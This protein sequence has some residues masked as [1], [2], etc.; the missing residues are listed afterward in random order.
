M[1]SSKNGQLG[2]QQFLVTTD[3]TGTILD[4]PLLD[5]KKEKECLVMEPTMVVFTLPS[6]PLEWL[7]Q[8]ALPPVVR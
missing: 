5:R 1:S 3:N 7:C 2:C 4:V 8:F 6:C